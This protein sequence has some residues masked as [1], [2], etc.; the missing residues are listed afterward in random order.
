MASNSKNGK[1]NFQGFTVHR[2][3]LSLNMNSVGNYIHNIIKK[4]PFHSEKN[5]RNSH[6]FYADVK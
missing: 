6:K 2:E 4:N 3:F 5:K 1:S